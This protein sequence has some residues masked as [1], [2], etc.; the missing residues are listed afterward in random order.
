MSGR[1]CAAPPAV[2]TA[3]GP[4]NTLNLCALAYYGMSHR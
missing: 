4:L 2:A 1:P 3:I